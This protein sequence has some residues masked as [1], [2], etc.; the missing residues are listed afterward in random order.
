MALGLVTTLPGPN[1]GGFLF[2]NEVCV[3]R[4][5][6]AEAMTAARWTTER[7]RHVLKDHPAANGPGAGNPRLL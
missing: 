4:R 1:Q 5:V 2:W 7:W 3:L 6:S